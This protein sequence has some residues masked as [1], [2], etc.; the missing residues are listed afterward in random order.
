MSGIYDEINAQRIAAKAALVAG[1]YDD[2][3]TQAEMTLLD[4]AAI[5][6]GKKDGDAGAELSWDRE[7]IV[8]FIKLAKD[9]RADAAAT[10]NP[11]GM[12]THP[13]VCHHERPL[14]GGCYRG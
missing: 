13:F 5:P 10:S 1:R 7:A 3:I 14:R 11:M 2:A 6:D 8:A 9:A 4:L 12:T